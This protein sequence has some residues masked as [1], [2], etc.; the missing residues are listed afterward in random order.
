MVELLPV[1]SGEVVTVELWAEVEPEPTCG[2]DVEVQASLLVEVV[3]FAIG[4]AGGAE[5]EP[6]RP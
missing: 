4:T 5:R 2:E 1:R 3:P 6:A